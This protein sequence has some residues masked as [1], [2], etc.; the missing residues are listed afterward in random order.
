MQGSGIVN[1]EPKLHAAVFQ[2][3]FRLCSLC[4]FL[5]LPTLYVSQVKFILSQHSNAQKETAKGNSVTW[6]A[7]PNS[8]TLNNSN[9]RNLR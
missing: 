4:S 8:I 3:K 5:L 2:S 6:S 7:A 9:K 1:I